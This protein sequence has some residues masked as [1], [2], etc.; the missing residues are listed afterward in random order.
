MNVATAGWEAKLELVETLV[1]GSG[2][3]SVSLLASAT[4]FSR[5]S[6][7]RAVK[8]LVMDGRVKWSADTFEERR[9]RGRP[10]RLVVPVESSQPAASIAPSAEGEGNPAPP[11]ASSTVRS[12]LK[13]VKARGMFLTP[14]QAEQLRALLGRGAVPC[15]DAEEGARNR[16][17]S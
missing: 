1:N 10:G 2:G 14:E 6:V 4:G 8:T 9:T 17:E 3:V 15:S 11:R 16:E 5:D 13:P 12:A 7:E